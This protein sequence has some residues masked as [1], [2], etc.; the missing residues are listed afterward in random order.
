MTKCLLIILFLFTGNLFSQ[1]VIK[2]Y[3]PHNYGYLIYFSSL[4]TSNKTLIKNSLLLAS[5]DAPQASQ[6]FQWIYNSTSAVC[7]VSGYTDGDIKID[8]GTTRAVII[9]DAQYDSSV[10]SWITAGKIKKLWCVYEKIFD[11]AK[12]GIKNGK[13]MVREDYIKYNMSED[14]KDWNKYVYVVDT[15]TP[16]K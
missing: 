2:S 15:S 13:I 9:V 4:T 12:K 5:K 11:D 10:T 7:R 14:N 3:T 1:E 16:I 6:R 8:A